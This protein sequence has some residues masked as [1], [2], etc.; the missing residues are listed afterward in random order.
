MTGLSS[1]TKPDSKWGGKLK[2]GR[3]G[4]G[5]VRMHECTNARMHECTNARMH[6]CTNARM[7]GCARRRLKR[8]GI[9]LAV[10]NLAVNPNDSNGKRRNPKVGCLNYR[11]IFAGLPWYGR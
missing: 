8:P 5:Q 2:Q 1:L 9:G 6:E 10:A 11:P 4:G 3:A 7:H